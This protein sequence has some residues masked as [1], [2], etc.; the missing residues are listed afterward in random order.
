MIWAMVSIFCLGVNVGMLI[1]FT[2]TNI[3]ANKRRNEI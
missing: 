3:N 2:M 1:V